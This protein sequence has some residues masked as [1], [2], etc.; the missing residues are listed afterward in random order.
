MSDQSS[1]A[2][3]LCY[4]LYDYPD[5]P[6]VAWDYRGNDDGVEWA[7]VRY[8][9]LL[10][11]VYRGSVD[12][13]DWERDFYAFCDPLMHDKLGPVHP[14]FYKGLDTCVGKLLALAR[15][16]DTIGVTGHSL[17][18]GRASLATGLLCIAG[19]PPLTR[20][21]F[22]EPHSGTIELS[23]ITAASLG[24]SYRDTAGPNADWEDV[25]QVTMVPPWF[26]TPG[27]RTDLTVSPPAND[28]WGIFRFH[29]MSLYAGA[30][31]LQPTW[32]Y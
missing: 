26:E 3:T 8:N 24:P 9:G 23:K 25:D 4:A 2:A 11:A 29:H 30:V 21:V 13:Q 19:R 28:P 5:S 27:P 18:A 22:G 14:G 10:W 32:A 7:A 15:P 31:G 17:G 1:D 16:G 12:L 6:K 20:I